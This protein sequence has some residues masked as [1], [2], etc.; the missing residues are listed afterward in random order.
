MNWGLLSKPISFLSC[1]RR[2]QSKRPL[3]LRIP[4]HRTAK[5]THEPIGQRTSRALYCGKTVCRGWSP[6]H[7]YLNTSELSTSTLWLPCLRR[8]VCQAA[9]LMDVKSEAHNGCTPTNA[10]G[11]V[12]KQLTMD[13]TALVASTQELKSYWIPAKVAQVQWFL[14]GRRVTDQSTTS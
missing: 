1:V 13:Y 8:H 11:E 3:L 10:R 9:S 6:Q 14:P 2:C 7:T 4:T 5:H 12:Q